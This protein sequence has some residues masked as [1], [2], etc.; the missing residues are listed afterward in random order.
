MK[1]LIIGG[2]V[3]CTMFSISARYRSVTSERALD[4]YIS[5][6]K[7]VVA[8]FYSLNREQRK[9]R[10]LRNRIEHMKRMLKSTSNRSLYRSA[11]AYFTS[12]NIAKGD[13]GNTVVGLK[14]NQLPAFVLYHDGVVLTKQGVPAI[15]A[16]FIS[17]D[18]LMTFIDNH[19]E[20]EMRKYAKW[21][22][23]E[24]RRRAWE[25]SFYGPDLYSYPY[26][27]GYPYGGIGFGWGWGYPYYSR[28]G[29]Y[30]W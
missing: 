13:L 14:I 30:W 2:L 25:S 23:K 12:G 24:I 19:L 6:N 5:R 8:L 9:D 26:N 16:G 27:W 20:K 4:K 17:Q 3:L 29:R 7:F 11:D 22:A 1:R 10:E 21:R 18:Q 15:L 28:W